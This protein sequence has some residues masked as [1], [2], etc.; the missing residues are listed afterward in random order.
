MHV[1]GDTAASMAS[2]SA[3][4]SRSG[5][6]TV[7]MPAAWPAIS[8]SMKPWRLMIISPPGRP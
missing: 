1:R 8:Y 7:V 5:A 6:F 3:A 2:T 4:R